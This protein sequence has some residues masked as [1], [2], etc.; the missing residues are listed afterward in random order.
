MG[1][2]AGVGERWRVSEL[3]DRYVAAARYWS[4]TTSA[5]RQL[6]ARMVA[7]DRLGTIQVARLNPVVLQATVDR[8]V[9]ESVGTATIRAAHDVVRSAVSW[10]VAQG[11]LA[12]D[13]LAG[14]RGPRDSSPRSQV[15]VP[16]VRAAVAAACEEALRAERDARCGWSPASELALFRAQQRLLLVFLVA[17]TG[18]RRG[19][20]AGLRSDDLLGREL[21]IER[22]VKS[23][24]GGRMIGPTKSHRHGRVTIAAATARFWQDHVR[25]WHGRGAASGMRSVWLFTATPWAARP[26]SPCT[27]AYRFAHVNALAGRGDATLH[28]VRHTVATSLA[29][30]GKLVQ[31]QKRLRHST[32]DTTARYYVDPTGLDDEAVADELER[33]F[34][35]GRPVD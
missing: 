18:L 3:M 31:A 17:D 22:A 35:V 6:G 33:V 25:T 19:E 30:A 10:A 32:M 11:W 13:V 16:A 8:W 14:A 24:P 5:R 2:L 4:P 9:A 23:A 12:A 20:L 21:W 27:L 26:T 15:P 28:G 7:G 29:R 1:M 34:L